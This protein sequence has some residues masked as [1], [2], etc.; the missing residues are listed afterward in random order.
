MIT[1]EKENASLRSPFSFAHST[2]RAYL[3][4]SV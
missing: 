3:Y 4:S 1:Q 2:S